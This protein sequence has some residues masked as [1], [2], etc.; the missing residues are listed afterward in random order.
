MESLLVSVNKPAQGIVS[1]L[2]GIAVLLI[3]ATTVF[4]ELQNALDPFRGASDVIDFHHPEVARLAAALRSATPEQTARRCF[5]WVRDEVAHS[6]DFQREEITCTASEA[7][8]AGTGLCISKSH[9][10]VALLRANGMASGF[11][12]QRLRLSGAESRFCT[13]GLIAVYLERQGWYRCDARGNKATVDC[14]FTPGREQL[15]FEARA[16]GE[17]LYPGVWAQPW[18][19]LVQRL[20]A[21]PSIA[22]YLAAPI[23]V[24]PPGPARLAV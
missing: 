22:A 7:L 16:E 2:I 13:H 14:Q 9:L 23:D 17:Q 10:A 11:C 18:P 3:G 5:E 1:T 4:G 15:A 19:E 6:I 12:Y 21:L 24:S 20:Q 8:A